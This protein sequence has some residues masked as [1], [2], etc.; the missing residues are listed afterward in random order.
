MVG[1]VCAV[2]SWHHVTFIWYAVAGCVPTTVFGYMISLF[3]MP[4]LEN[5]ES[6]VEWSDERSE[7]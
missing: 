2:W 3:A 6:L 4:L 7:T 5:S 1:F